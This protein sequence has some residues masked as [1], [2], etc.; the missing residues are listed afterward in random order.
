LEKYARGT[1]N[2]SMVVLHSDPAKDSEGEIGFFWF[3]CLTVDSKSV[4]ILKSSI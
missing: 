3:C 2:I 4:S 1:S